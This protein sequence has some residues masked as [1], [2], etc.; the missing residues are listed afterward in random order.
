M[1]LE[2]RRP[3][4]DKLLN[5]IT[6]GNDF[7]ISHS[8]HKGIYEYKDG[9]KDPIHGT[10]G[11]GAS[12]Y[13]KAYVEK[14]P[15]ADRFKQ[16]RP[17]VKLV[18]D[19]AHPN[20][21]FVNKNDQPKFQH[22]FHYVAKTPDD[23][24][25]VKGPS[26]NREVPYVQA[27]KFGEALQ[28]KPLSQQQREN[29]DSVLPKIKVNQ[30]K[31]PI[32]FAQEG[33][34]VLQENLKSFRESNPDAKLEKSPYYNKAFM[35]NMRSIRN[36]SAKDVSALSRDFNYTESLQRQSIMD[37]KGESQIGTT[38]KK[39]KGIVPK[40]DQNLIVDQKLVP[41]HVGTT[42][43]GRGKEAFIFADE[44]E[45]FRSLNPNVHLKQDQHSKDAYIINRF[46]LNEEGRENLKRVLEQRDLGPTDP[47]FYAKSISVQAKEHQ[48][49]SFLK[50][51]GVDDIILEQNNK[52]YVEGEKNA[53]KL[54]EKGF[55]LSKPWTPKGK[56]SKPRHYI[57][58]F[59]AA[60]GFIPNLAP[61]V[62]I[63]RGQR[64]G[65]VARPNIQEEYYK[66]F[67]AAKTPEDIV[68]LVQGFSSAHSVGA[69]SGRYHDKHAKVA[70]LLSPDWHQQQKPFGV[71]T[72]RTA[73]DGGVLMGDERT[74]PSGATSW[75]TSKNVAREFS[76]MPDAADHSEASY[77]WK[78]RADN[79]IYEKEV[80]L[81]NVFSKQKLLKY[82][83]MGSD[84]SKGSYPKVEEFKKSLFSG[85]LKEWAQETGGVYL[86][87]SGEYG[88]A[89][90]KLHGKTMQPMIPV[91]DQRV[92]HQ[93]HDFRR[94]ER[95]LIQ[96]FGEGMVPNLSD[97]VAAEH[98][99]GVPMHRIR[100][101]QHSSIDSPGNLLVYD[102]QQGGP[103]GA[104]GD[105]KGARGAMKDSRET[106][107]SLLS[108]G[109]MVPN[110]APRRK[111]SVYDVDDTLIKTSREIEKMGL[112]GRDKF[113][114]YSDP[115][116]SKDVA[117][118]AE[119]T[120]IG[121]SLI[122]DPDR[123]NAYMLTAAA[124]SRN[125]ILAK[126]FDMPEERILSLQDEYVRNLYQL[127]QKVPS[128]I[129]L[130]R[131]AQGLPLREGTR[132]YRKLTTGE[133]KKK[134]LD[135]LSEEGSIDTTLF[136]DNLEVIRAVGGFGKHIQV[137]AFW[138]YS[139]SGGSSSTNV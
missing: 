21:L 107:G 13:G 8:N 87:L 1:R 129:G 15:A 138:V 72:Q 109:G 93:D 139:K 57:R 29:E 3:P 100:I 108:G 71:A 78:K 116:L 27:Q 68:K 65:P 50:T 99:A 101:G 41:I 125:K 133:Q 134:V 9:L 67:K 115:T 124:P 56:D 62:N 28:A 136:D 112:T 73:K 132:D 12:A 5:F 128:Q 23:F 26:I 59:P 74:R 70:D 80:P 126:R 53:S 119:L 35:I 51:L 122:K 79:E 14:G 19:A 82:L 118:N 135:S 46:R 16:I 130:R 103:S 123:A 37:S 114:G 76:K 39:N 120:S 75:T 58:R 95:E 22:L 43:A 83:N 49:M 113:K 121:R 110:L 25:N 24:I 81:K 34:Y 36:Q 61:T 90:P 55:S 96:V 30:D 52:K 94:R 91:S 84:P 127:D 137:A 17:D 33:P 111:L 2:S 89:T 102:A 54:K 6:L 66:P 77:V 64:Q 63:Q 31:H 11:I 86:N 92:G 20:K 106:R 38:S 60:E 47:N 104:I 42:Q 18:G 32:Y 97:A 40:P 45:K 117:A 131:K 7:Q 69:L 88:K 98:A 105:H 44:V 85:E 48:E 4:E 10:F